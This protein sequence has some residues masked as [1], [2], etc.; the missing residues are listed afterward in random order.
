MDTNTIM[1]RDI[2][3]AFIKMHVLYHAAK[4]DVFGIGLPFYL[5]VYGVSA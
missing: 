3:L 4:E 2:H 5:A 1:L